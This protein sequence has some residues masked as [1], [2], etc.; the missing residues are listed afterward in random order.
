MTLSP[1]QEDQI[2]MQIMNRP[3]ERGIADVLKGKL[4]IFLLM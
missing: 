4:I 3:R 2:I 1:S